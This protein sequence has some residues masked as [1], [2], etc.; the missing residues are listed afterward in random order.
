MARVKSFWQLISPFVVAVFFMILANLLQVVSF[1][2]LRKL[3]IDHYAL[4]N[5]GMYSITFLAVVMG[6]FERWLMI[7]L[8]TLPFYQRLSAIK[9]IFKKTNK[10]IPVLIVVL[11]I[12]FGILNPS[13]FPY[14]ILSVFSVLFIFISLFPKAL[15]VSEENYVFLGSLSIIEPIFRLA[16]VYLFV[17][18]G[19]ITPFFVGHL[20]A[21]ASVG[22]ISY[23]TF[24]KS[25]ENPRE[26]E[27]EVPQIKL[28]V[29]EIFGQI[30]LQVGVSIFW[31]A[32]GLLL[33]SL[34]SDQIYATYVTYAYIMKFPL[35]LTISFVNVL[36]IKNVI[37]REQQTQFKKMMILAI[38]L[39]IGAFSLIGLTDTV[40]PGAITAFL[41]FNQYYVPGILFYM[42]IVWTIHTILTILFTY[43]L[44]VEQGPRLIL[45]IGSYM[46]SFVI[47]LLVFNSDLFTLLTAI[48]IQGIIF[49]FAVLFSQKS[50]FRK[51]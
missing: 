49:L 12:I 26:E 38:F 34:L 2:A 5:Y 19:N 22:V 41:G 18:N 25:L 46:I 32:D 24:K 20:L 48:L 4:L 13:A 1:S 29:N 27:T 44:K 40:L 50:F 47:M 17:Q 16:T 36:T 7:R 43:L 15:V 37:E 9:S 8:S 31:I 39:S 14:I 51:K 21:S 33:K 11:G 35:L 42:S 45:N 28:E 6:S 3:D 30:L 23:F 10:P